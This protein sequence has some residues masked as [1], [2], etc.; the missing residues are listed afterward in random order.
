MPSLVANQ[1]TYTPFTHSLEIT[2]LGFVRVLFCGNKMV[3][4]TGGQNPALYPYHVPGMIVCFSI[5]YQSLSKTNS[6][7]FPPTKQVQVS[8]R[9][10][11][12]RLRCSYVRG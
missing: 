12:T 1:T 4:R 9:P 11:R 10:E 8:R 5:W 6:E 3:D 2:F 7:Y